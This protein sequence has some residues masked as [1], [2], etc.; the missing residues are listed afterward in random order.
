M[1]KFLLVLLFLIEAYSLWGVVYNSYHLFTS[2]TA[3]MYEVAYLDY[4]SIKFNGDKET[5]EKN[6]VIT[7]VS[8]TV[9]NDSNKKFDDIRVRLMYYN[10]KHS[11][12]PY[13][14]G[15]SLYNKIIDVNSNGETVITF[16]EFRN[17]WFYKDEYRVSLEYLFHDGIE[18][19]SL[20]CWKPLYT[21][22]EFKNDYHRAFM[23]FLV[24]CSIIFVVSS[25]LIVIVIVKN[26][27]RTKQDV[28]SV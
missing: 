9:I 10:D 2:S 20:E 5:L 22:N 13:P 25:T 21:G 16:T 8:V 26:K 23:S 6:E 12:D 19:D 17:T 27:R 4:S 1:K 11:S 24:F 14:E 15:Y 18:L 3:E 28:F 7:S